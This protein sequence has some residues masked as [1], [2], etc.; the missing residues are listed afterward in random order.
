MQKCSSAP[1]PVATRLDF[2]EEELEALRKARDHCGAYLKATGR[3][4][5]LYERLCE[6]L[7]DVEA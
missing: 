1:A 2:D 3:A 4:S 5:S 7:T 6:R